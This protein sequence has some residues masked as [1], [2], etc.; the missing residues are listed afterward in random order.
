MISGQSS[1]FRISLRSKWNQEET[2]ADDARI[3]RE[4]KEREVSNSC[5]EECIFILFLVNLGLFW[6]A[7]R[8]PS[9]HLSIYL[10]Y[11]DTIKTWFEC[12]CNSVHFSTPGQKREKVGSPLK[13]KETTKTLL[14]LKCLLLGSKRFSI[15]SL[16]LTEIWD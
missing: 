6:S 5:P 4:Q 13:Y 8:K 11:I 3:R 16:L 1:H 10:V 9:Y 15:L 12:Y 2:E 7:F 14:K